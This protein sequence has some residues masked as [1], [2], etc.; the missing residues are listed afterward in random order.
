MEQQQSPL[1][2]VAEVCRFTTYSR[3][4]IFKLRAEDK[5]PSAVSLGE[6]RIAFVRQEIEQWYESRL[7]E[8]GATA[9]SKA[10]RSQCEGAGEI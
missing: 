7:A 10:M 9:W 8:R 2:T 4:Q 1:M 3:T 6:K 5:F